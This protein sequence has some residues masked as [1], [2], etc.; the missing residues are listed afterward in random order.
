MC[1]TVSLTKLP[2]ESHALGAQ[3]LS[4]GYDG[5]LVVFEGGTSP[6][7]LPHNLAS[8]SPPPP[9]ASVSPTPLPA[10]FSPTH[11]LQVSRRNL[12]AIVALLGVPE[13]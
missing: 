5:R 10:S 8:V 3:K 4:G 1:V 11:S 12:P 6:T 9:P 7:A 2:Y 13:R